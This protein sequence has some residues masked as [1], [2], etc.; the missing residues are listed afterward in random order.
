M[1]C[2]SESNDTSQQAQQLLVIA[3]SLMIGIILLFVAKE[4]CIAGTPA[5]WRIRIGTCAEMITY[6]AEFHSLLFSLAFSSIC[7]HN[8]TQVL[9][10]CYLFTPINN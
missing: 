7:F 3:L 5:V 8:M 1:K 6:T 9:Y 10:F 4:A 2:A